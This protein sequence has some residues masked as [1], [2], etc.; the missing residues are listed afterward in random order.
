MEEVTGDTSNLFIEGSKG[1]FKISTLSR[2]S[3]FRASFLPIPNSL[4]K[5]GAQQR[6][7]EN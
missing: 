1:S 4:F 7:F 6:Y 2:D 3:F 5:L